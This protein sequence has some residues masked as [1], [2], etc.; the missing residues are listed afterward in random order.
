MRATE[1]VTQS[2]E[3]EGKEER[4]GAQEEKEGLSTSLIETG[5]QQ[6][7]KKERK[8][9]QRPGK[10]GWSRFEF[11]MFPATGPMRL[12]VSLIMFNVLLNIWPM[13]GKSPAPGYIAP[14]KFVTLKL[15]FSDF[16]STL[17]KNEI[18]F[19]AV[20]GNHLRYK[21][22]PQSSVFA[23]LGTP[24]DNVEQIWFDSVKPRDYR[25]PYD[26]LL[27]NGA[28]FTTLERTFWDEASNVLV[29]FWCRMSQFVT[30]ALVV[31]QMYHGYLSM[32]LY[33]CIHKCILRWITNT[34]TFV[35]AGIC[36]R[37]PCSDGCTEQSVHEN[38]TKR[39]CSWRKCSLYD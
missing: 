15:P 7:P 23:R 28:R 4:E 26:T 6:G 31:L 27:V 22:K 16:L 11:P 29:C 12:F 33:S 20:D 34:C 30:C 3:S 9:R 14:G 36:H 35:P 24:T 18:A 13:Q 17:K 10:K 1:N 38:A 37:I 2:E 25:V 8:R 19:M 21:L 5:E 32:H 39:I